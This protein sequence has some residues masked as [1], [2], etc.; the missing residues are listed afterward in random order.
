MQMATMGTAVGVLGLVGVATIDPVTVG[1]RLSQIGTMGVL[2][3]CV[4]ALTF[5]LV[6][7]DRRAD[8][9]SDRNA[10]RNVTVAKEIAAALQA[11]T[12]ATAT[13]AKINVELKTALVD[14]TNAVRNMTKATE[15]CEQVHRRG[16]T[17]P[18]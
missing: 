15:W 18:L 12:D 9:L 17:L 11:S 16:G 7:K 8:E 4:V 6:R 5:A 1:G 14:N 2:G 13:Q 3:T 10:E